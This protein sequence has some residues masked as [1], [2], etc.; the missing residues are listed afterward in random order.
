ML[1]PTSRCAFP[2]ARFGDVVLMYVCM[3]FK[4]ERDVS[5]LAWLSASGSQSNV[6][7]ARLGR[8]FQFGASYRIEATLRSAFAILYD[9]AMVAVPSPD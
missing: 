1:R 5:W 7:A 2:P 9:A 3:W 4:G 6:M 8:Y